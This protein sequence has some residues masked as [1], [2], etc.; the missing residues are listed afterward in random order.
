MW[1][2]IKIFRKC[3]DFD[4]VSKNGTLKINQAFWKLRYFEVK[5]M[6]L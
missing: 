4:D 1:Q 3:Y 2:F 6:A 5:V